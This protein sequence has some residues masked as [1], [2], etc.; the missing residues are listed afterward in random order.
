MQRA[1][2]GAMPMTQQDILTHYETEWKTK[3]DTAS[4]PE[5][6]KYSNPV[7]DA[8]LYPA[9]ERLIGDLSMKADGGRVLDVGSGSGRWVRF[10]LERFQPESLMGVDYSEASVELLKRWHPSEKTPLEFR[11]ADIT[12]PKLDLGGDFDL[13]NVANVLFHIPEPEL[14]AAAL[15]NLAR[16]VAPTG[17]IV[18]TEYLPRTTMRTEWMMVRSR[19]DFQAAVKSVGLHV[20]DVRAFSFFSN[21]PLGIDGPDDGLRRRFNTVRAHVQ[22]LLASDLDPQSRKFFIDFLAEIERATLGFARERIADLDMPS[23]KLVVLKK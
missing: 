17:H 2:D 10:F 20:C 23:Q 3:S 7:E 13:I 1:D 21:D 9:Y 6:L 22:K 19:Y 12:K 16:L 11:I 5:G 8:V 18:T 15:E 4:G 14:F